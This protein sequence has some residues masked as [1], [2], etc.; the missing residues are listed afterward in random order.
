MSAPNA[1]SLTAQ[2]YAMLSALA[3]P[4]TRPRRPFSISPTREFGSQTVGSG[5]T[6]LSGEARMGVSVMTQSPLVGAS[7]FLQYVG[8]GGVRDGLAA[9]THGRRF[10][11]GARAR[12]EPFVP[13]GPPGSLVVRR[14]GEPRVRIEPALARGALQQLVVTAPVTRRTH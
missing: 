2:P 13:G 7:S 12:R 4:I 10:D 11:G 1:R 9:D 14:G 6:A 5:S 3:T 8:A